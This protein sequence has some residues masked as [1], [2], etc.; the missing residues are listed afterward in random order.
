ML[1]H[2]LAENWFNVLSA[3]GIIGGLLFTAF[4]LR[5][6]TKTRRIANLLTITKNH[7]EI[8]SEFSKRPELHGIFQKSPS[9][10]KAKITKNEEI[11]VTSVILHLNSVYEA[12]KSGLVI[13]PEGLRRDV[14]RFFSLPVVRDVWLN[15]K[16]LQ[17]DDFV[18]FVDD[19]F[20]PS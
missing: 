4:S 9:S 14:A 8:W 13:K 18:E 7:R 16:A 1:L 12:M 2:W 19:C 11:F 3:I 20:D 15:A 5:S 17:N 6:E 10:P